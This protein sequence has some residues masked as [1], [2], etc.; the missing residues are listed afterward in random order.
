MIIKKI[1]A[2]I[3]KWAKTP[4]GFYTIG[5]L[6][7]S[8]IVLF[9]D[10]IYRSVWYVDDV[11]NFWLNIHASIIEVFLLGLF[12]TWFNKL[13]QDKK[14]KKENIKRWLEEM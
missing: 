11:K 14:E 3:R 1:W 8:V 9:I 12:I 7:L 6:S 13:S 2:K 4:T 5:F 10:F